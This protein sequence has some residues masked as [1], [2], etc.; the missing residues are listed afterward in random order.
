TLKN[1]GNAG[2]WENISV[3]H[4]QYFFGENGF[5]T[6]DGVPILPPM[7]FGVAQVFDP[8]TLQV[9]LENI[10]GLLSEKTAERYVP[11]VIRVTVEAAEGVR[12]D[13]LRSR[14]AKI[15]G[16]VGKANTE[17]AVR[18][19]KGVASLAESHVTSAVEEACLGVAQ[20]QTSALIAASAGTY[21]GTA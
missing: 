10:R 21:A 6:V 1:L 16:Q 8:A 9:N 4:T 15:P 11:D 17:K 20:F 13:S 2:L 7:H 14:F 19:F 5:V 3:A 18:W 12:Y